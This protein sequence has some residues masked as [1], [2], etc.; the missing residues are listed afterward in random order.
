[1][2]LIC[3][4]FIAAHWSG[5]HDAESSLHSYIVSAGTSPGDSSLLSPTSLPPSSS[6][7]LQPFTLPLPT[8][9]TVFVTLVAVSNA[10]GRVSATS[11]GVFIDDMPPTIINITVDTM[12][13]GSISIATQ[14]SNTVLR[15]TWNS[16]NLLSPIHSNYW[17]ILPHPGTAIPRDE[18]NVNSRESGT[19]SGLVLEDGAE[20]SVS[21]TS[22]NAAGLCTRAE[23]NTSVLADGSPP[24][25]GFFAVAT[26]STFPRSVAVP[27]GMAWRNRPRAGDSRIT[28]SFY[29]F[30]DAHSRITEYWVEVATGFGQSDLTE[31]ASLLSPSV[32]PVTES[33]TA[34]VAT[35]G[36]VSVNQ[37][38][39]LSLWAVNQAGLASR[40][41]HASFVVEEMEGEENRG[42]LGHLRSSLCSLDSCLGHCTCA[43]RG[44]LCPLPSSDVMSCER[45]LE[46][47]VSGD[48]KV[49]VVNV[50]PQQ[51]AGDDL[52]TSLTDK[53][54]VR[55]VE[56]DP[57]PYQRLEWTVGEVGGAPGSGLFDTSADQIWREVGSSSSA[58]FS[59]NPLRP[60]LH[61][62]TYVVYVRAWFNFT[63][64]V[65]F[66]SSGI[67]VDVSGPL[68]ESGGRV[69]EGGLG[70]E[71][72]HTAN[73]TG[74][75]VMWT[76]VF[77]NELSTVYSSYQ[78]G[79]GDVPGSDN[80]VPFTPS[81][82]SPLS[83]SASFSHN[84]RYYTTL[85]ATSPLS[86][87]MDTISDGF[88]VDTTP[89]TVGVVFDGL[90]YRDEIAQSATNSLSARW[91]GFHDAE[92]G[93]H[94][95][96]VAVSDS[97]S[98]A[99]DLEYENVGIRL[100]WTINDL[101]LEHGVTYYVHL[102]AV[103]G[104]GVWSTP[105]SSN[106][107]TVDVTRPDHLQCQWEPVNLTSFEPISSGASPCK[108]SLVQGVESG[109]TFLPRSLSFSPLS[110]CVSHQLSGTL[111]LSLPTS[112]G[113]LHTFSFW[114]VRQPGGSGCGHPT[115]LGARVTAPG[116]EEVV[117]T[118]TRDGDRLDR[119]S[120]FHFRFTADSSSSV[121]TL[122]PLSDQSSL[123]LDDFVV[124]RCHSID[125][126]VPF[127]E[128]VTNRSS[129]FQ[130][131][132]EHI[133]GRWTRLRVS[134]EVG[135]EGR[136]VREYKWAIGTTE[137]GEQ[138]Q[139]FTSTGESPL[140]TG[141]GFDYLI[142]LRVH[143]TWREQG[144]GHIPF[145]GSVP[146][147]G[148]VEPVWPGGC[149]TWRTLRC[150]LHSP[151][152]EGRGR[153]QRWGGRGGSG[154]SE[155]GRAAS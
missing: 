51:L 106:G 24:V 7:F 90:G 129:V 84:H 27:D 20:Y 16:E 33:F 40:K 74:I 11:D 29:G 72:D 150:G 32:D 138:L 75:D 97:P 21:V 42:T 79:I 95:Y 128:V 146:V 12:W 52:F 103:N 80:V 67:T 15:A 143:P 153:S 10:G 115:P 114:L 147:S 55:W 46:E 154:V 96:E 30:S 6:S 38:L 134:W 99:V 151:R 132:Q 155:L 139:P 119:W 117:L 89:P 62:E 56:P 23:T 98:P 76:G 125:S 49:G 61:G 111:S 58:I 118:H 123:V 105:V 82:S 109:V 48:Q 47:F 70:A 104:A 85:R 91:A 131:S 60:L 101:G 77:I 78:I 124:S 121:L 73:Q 59:V 100:S 8:N 41:V 112:P 137:G 120:Q 22:C 66:E 127:S 94:H 148:G 5:F 65:I 144:A 135:E 37:T 1:M 142:W 25:D 13:A 93:I 92:S 81:P 2:I 116:L 88:L 31:G 68:T 140:I 122:S 108:D 4:S 63:H 3:R 26:D 133:S 64:F 36:H 53:L 87:S 9:I 54:L 57:S 50:S 83:L 141:C 69:R 35:V 130:V 113:S 102:A 107:I 17:F 19:A 110:G 28:L 45:V 44:D 136:E 71:I 14:F 126:S 39:Y 18:E 34:T 149:G 152:A 43:T 145:P 86:V